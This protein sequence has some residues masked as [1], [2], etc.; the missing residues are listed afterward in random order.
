[1][2][3]KLVMSGLYVHEKR[4]VIMVSRLSEL[5]IDLVSTRACWKGHEGLLMSASLYLSFPKA[6]V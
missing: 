2:W 6:R 4:V 5:F 3:Y 1:M